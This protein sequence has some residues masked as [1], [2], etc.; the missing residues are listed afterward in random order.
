MTAAPPAWGMLASV[1]VG[2]VE[3]GQPQW[4]WLLVVLVPAVVWV[5]RRSLSGLAP[6]S[7]KVALVVRLLVVAL[8]VS[9]LARPSVRDRAEGVAVV[10]V[11]DRSRSVP[12]GMQDR[13]MSQVR[14]LVEGGLG[15]S[16]SVGLVSFAGE[17]VVESLPRRSLPEAD[18][19]YA[20]RSD[21][22]NL[23]EAVRLALAVR[24]A[25]A[26]FRVLLVSDGNETVGDLLAEARAAR[27]QGVPIDVMPVRYRYREEVVV[28]RLIAPATAR[29]GETA[30]LRVT[31]RAWSP[32]TGRLT[33]LANGSPLSIAAQE[34][35]PGVRVT[36]EEGV[37]SFVV[38]I[39][40]PAEEV[41][42]FEAVYEPDGLAEGAGDTILENN[43]A[44]ATTFVAGQGKVLVLTE[45]LAASAPLVEALR[46]GGI[47]V[48]R[49]S[50]SGLPESLVGMSGFDAI[51]LMDQPATNFSRMSMDHLR[52]YV[53]DAG[54]GLV[55][56]GGPNA[57]GAGGWIGSPLEDALPIRLDPPQR[58]RLPRGAMAIVIDTSG[59][60]GGSVGG[61]QLSQLDIAKEGAIAGIAS[62][63]AKDL[64]TVIR[65]DSTAGLV[66]PLAEVGDKQGFSSAIRRMAIGGGTN[67]APGL[68][69]ALDQLEQ[70]EAAVKH[71]VVLSD[72]QTTGSD[73]TFRTIIRRAL[74]AGVSI[75]TVTIGDFT[76][77][78]LMQSLASATR[79]RYYSVTVANSRA[80]L[81]Q[82]FIR[83]AQT[84]SRPL[85]WEGQ[86]FVPSFTPGL[87]EATRGIRSVPPLSGYIVAGDRSGMSVVSMR[88]KEDDPILAQW[89]HGLG[90]VVAYTSDATSRWNPM[91][92]AWG[93]YQRFW[94]QHV[95]WVMRASGDANVRVVTS[96]QGDR[97]AITVE[98]TD[99]S[100]RRLNFARFGGLLSAPDG[101][102]MPVRL[103]QTGPGLYT[104]SVPTAQAGSY[105]LSLSYDAP[106]GDGQR[107]KGLVRAAIDRPFADEFRATQANEALLRRVAELTGG[108]VIEPDADGS[109]SPW[110]RE[111]LEMPVTLT[112]A[113]LATAMLAIAAFLVDVGVRRVRV[114]VQAIARWFRLAARQKAPSQSQQIEALRAARAKAKER[115]VR[116]DDDAPGQA[117]RQAMRSEDRKAQAKA[118]YEPEVQAKPASNGQGLEALGG[119]GK[120][121]AGPASGQ[122]AA[123]S[124][125]GK[126]PSAD[127]TQQEEAQAMSRLLRAKQRTRSEFEER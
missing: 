44:L 34:G 88:G 108:A 96:E 12:P 16:D 116:G 36:L 112:S 40:I 85:V 107:L 53:H 104:G 8:L 9:A 17:A 7:R 4:L 123:A 98:A 51:V 118:R 75:S 13:A 106:G 33:I 2:P 71:I 3:L 76:N 99:A 55:M 74:R 21:Q 22:T 115:L 122:P 63:T 32:S 69:M 81:P 64:A 47:I 56:V 20:G 26:G 91:W 11:V 54:G 37:N 60:M 117:V 127:G 89:Q 73:Q 102:S 95:R 48:E 77:D 80:Q 41:L 110:R 28:E 72:G 38:P 45:D 50:A 97:T 46:A 111:G 18:R 62:L 15:R 30:N 100:G 90:R 126:A 35:G 105:L 124:E 86:P 57:F 119:G 24:P 84:I 59:S 19:A 87:T 23:A 61:L 93:D 82:I 109:P 58:R 52:R 66:V 65:F 29:E 5:G 42:R 43:R 83:E 39:R 92:L 103:E 78:A 67:M 79:G 6:G 121:R 14:S 27:A 1:V 125:H 120:R 68:E 25:T 113:W 114:D 94:Q 31:L 10:V 49:R 101:S 70:A